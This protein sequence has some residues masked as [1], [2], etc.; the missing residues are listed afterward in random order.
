MQIV[1]RWSAGID[2]YIKDFETLRVEAPS[3]CA[4]CGCDKHYRWGKYARN[5]VEATE[6]YRISVRRICC[7]NCRVTVSYLPD[8]CLSGIEY[9]ARLVIRLLMWLI[10]GAEAPV[11]GSGNEHIIHR[12][13]AYRR[14]F[15]RKES[16]WLTFL[17]GRTTEMVPVKGKG[18]TRGIFFSL[19]KLWRTGELLCSFNR[20]TGRHF[21]SG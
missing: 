5:V 18:R 3:R 10:F 17:R 14:R 6:T 16:L 11:P 2:A 9:S 12:G 21:M 15:E 13:Y 8:F 20:E 4:R 1:L 19:H 7:A